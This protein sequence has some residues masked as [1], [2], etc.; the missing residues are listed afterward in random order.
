MSGSPKAERGK[1]TEEKAPRVAK[2]QEGDGYESRESE[3]RSLRS[4]VEKCRE[5]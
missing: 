2:V 1:L 3:H 5:L 4:H